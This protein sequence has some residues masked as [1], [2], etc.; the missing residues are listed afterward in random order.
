MNDELQG[1]SKKAFVKSSL[2]WYISEAT[3][4]SE[5]FVDF[6]WITQHYVSR[7]RTLHNQRILDLT[8]YL[9]SNQGTIPAFT[10]KDLGKQQKPSCGIAGFLTEF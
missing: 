10:W 6:G 9:W 5:M 1:I 4:S 7:G 2:F 8:K 3:C